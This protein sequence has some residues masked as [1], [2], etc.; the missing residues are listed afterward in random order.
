MSGRVIESFPV[1]VDDLFRKYRQ[2]L[3]NVLYPIVQCRATAEDLTHETY[4]RLTKM[5]ARALAYP[6]AFL[7][8]TARNLA[9]D[10]VRRQAARARLLSPVGLVADAEPSS[11]RAVMAQERINLFERVLD[12][13]PTRCREVFILR[14]LHG[15]SYAEISAQL[16]ISRGATEKH[17][18]RALARCRAA[19]Q[20][21]YTE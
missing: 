18:V 3:I 1:D 5:N 6:R 16:G 9:I 4:L 19:L 2:E 11:E 20:R 21:Y 7:F 10:H 8:R 13:L 15:L 12:E 17:I 14:K